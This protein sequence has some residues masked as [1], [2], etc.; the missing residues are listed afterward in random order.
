MPMLQTTWAEKPL[1]GTAGRRANSEEWNTITRVAQVAGIGFGHPVQRG[2]ADDQANKFTTGK[3]LGITEQDVTVVDGPVDAAQ[4]Y[5]LGA[6][7]PI[8]DMG[9]IWAKAS[10]ACTAGGLVYWDAAAKGY[11]NTASGTLIPG[12]EFD[13]TAA[14]NG[15]VKIRLRRTPAAP[16]A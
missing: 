7:L 9:T 1:P 14:A 12:A 6:N 13:S 11:S 2:T 4:E 3:F 10:G 5:P 8:C 16:A 15:V